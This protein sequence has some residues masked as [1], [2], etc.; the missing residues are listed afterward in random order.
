MPFT[1]CRWPGF[2]LVLR[3]GATIFH[4][5]VENP[6]GV[7]RGVERALFDGQPFDPTILP[8]VHGGRTHEVRLT[9]G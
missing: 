4:V 6:R 5:R 8:R 2:E 9:M 1:R 7:N 3:D